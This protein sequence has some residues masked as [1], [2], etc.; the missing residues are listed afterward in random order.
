MYYIM[1]LLANGVEGLQMVNTII[2]KFEFLSNDGLFYKSVKNLCFY[3]F[4]YKHIFFFL[5]KFE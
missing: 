1:L 3:E 5:V 4:R 2:I